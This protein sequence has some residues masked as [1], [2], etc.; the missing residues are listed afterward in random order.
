MLILGGFGLL[1]AIDTLINIRPPTPGV[2]CRAI[3][4][5]TL[6]AIEIFGEAVGARFGGLLWLI[7][8]AAFV[9]FGYRVLKESQ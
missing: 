3:C 4:G 8:S 2:G 1:A 6:M 5:L 9:V 7:L